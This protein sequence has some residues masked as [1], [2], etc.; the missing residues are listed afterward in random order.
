MSTVEYVNT[1]RVAFGRVKLPTDMD[2]NELAYHLRLIELAAGAGDP[3][4]TRI[5]TH[6]KKARK[7]MRIIQIRYGHL[8]SS[9][10]SVAI[11]K[12]WEHSLDRFPDG[13]DLNRIVTKFERLLAAA[14]K[15]RELVS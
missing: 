11:G 15:K 13:S 10:V 5:T 7:A 1:L 8:I 9:E 4:Y 2:A 12:L 3:W 14:A 6:T